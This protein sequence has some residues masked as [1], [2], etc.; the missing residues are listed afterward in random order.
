MMKNMYNLNGIGVITVEYGRCED[1][2]PHV[3]Y[4]KAYRLHN[5][6]NF[7][8]RENPAGNFGGNSSRKM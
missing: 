7:L 6:L 8:Q 1:L 5:V 4:R 3:S 2:S